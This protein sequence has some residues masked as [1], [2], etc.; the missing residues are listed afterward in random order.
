MRNGVSQNQ[1]VLNHLIDHGYI[2][3]VIASSYGIRRLASR[4]HDL[5]VACIPVDREMR[6]DDAGV[7]YAYYTL[8]EDVRQ[9]E[10]RHRAEGKQWNGSYVPKAAA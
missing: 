5:E 2:T 9:Y 6:V 10:R 8:N 7:K 1:F 3:Q 4:I